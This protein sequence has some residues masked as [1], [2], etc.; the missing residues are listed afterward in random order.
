MA[1]SFDTA[2]G[3]T[4]FNTILES[5][6]GLTEDELYES[7]RLAAAS[8][9]ANLKIPYMQNNERKNRAMTIRFLPEMHKKFLE[10]GNEIIRQ[11]GTLSAEIKRKA[12]DT[13][14]AAL[15]KGDVIIELKKNGRRSAYASPEMAKK[16]HDHKLELSDGHG[17]TK[18]YD[19]VIVVDIKN[20]QTLANAFL[21]RLQSPNQAQKQTTVEEI[22]AAQPSDATALP[23]APTVV[24]Q[25]ADKKVS[26][27]Q[28]KDAPPAEKPDLLKQ[29][30]KGLEAERQAVEQKQE[31]QKE[32]LEKAQ[33]IKEQESEKADTKLQES[34]IE[35]K[36]EEPI[37]TVSAALPPE[38]SASSETAR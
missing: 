23:A 28:K 17:K 2:G 5:L 14:T 22:K 38:T 37:P 16:I 34:L 4:D 36:K 6:T 30:E 13:F 18:N 27:G 15:T 8:K 29:Q 21:K 12:S 11:K 33:D 7:M 1:N 31:I 26:I 24:I 35:A 20:F 32:T 19:G 9:K 25:T 3:A 10:V